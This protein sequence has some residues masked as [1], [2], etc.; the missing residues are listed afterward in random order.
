[1]I[2]HLRRRP[3]ILILIA[4]IILLKI[5]QVSGLF[6]SDKDG[7]PYNAGETFE[8]RAVV[9]GAPE[10]RLEK[11]DSYTNLAIPIKTDEGDKAVIL[12]RAKHWH[13]PPDYGERWLFF[14]SLNSEAT[15]GKQWIRADSRKSEQ[16]PGSYGNRFISTCYAARREA[17]SILRIGIDEH[18]DAVT[19]I[20]AVL[21]G[22]RSSFS[23]SLRE[24]FRRTGTLHIFA[25][26][27][28]HVGIIA[29]LLTFLLK[30][31]GVSRPS[32]IWYMAPLLI[33]YTIAT[34]GRAS[35]VRAC[36]MMILL[37]LAPVL[38]RKADTLS[39]IAAAAVLILMAAP[40]QINDIGFIY[41]F[42]VVTG[43]VLICPIIERPLLK[44]IERDPLAII[45][46]SFPVRSLRFAAKSAISILSVSVAAWLASAPLTLY[47]FQRFA[48][49]APL[50]NLIVV[51]AAVLI[52]C[53]GC[54][55]LIFGAC[56]AVFAFALNN[57][58][59]LFVTFLKSVMELIALIPYGSFRTGHIT[60][61]IIP[62]W[63]TI[64]L[65]VIVT[66]NKRRN[67]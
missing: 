38:S 3:I 22:Y 67:R 6:N 20:H 59:L 66:I 41:S 64:L 42:T 45:P 58:N 26:S 52:V 49:I 29:M 46:E 24:V 13:K 60:V 5:V 8:L 32:W 48:P 15:Y 65:L 36:V 33:A 63:Y 25:I 34:G 16:L 47:F 31:A 28:L 30:W 2:R 50:S 17:A 55:S 37:Y 21:L 51:P 7:L 19:I 12:W 9:T 14:G 57:I 11:D 23:S 4:Y 27:G 1:M 40:G 53:T 61:W 62:A 44:S 10:P 56:A 54:L 43:I 39:A 35:A 18:G